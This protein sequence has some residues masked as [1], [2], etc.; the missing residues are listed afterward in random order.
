MWVW[1]FVGLLFSWLIV[2]STTQQDEPA[3]KLWMY[4]TPECRSCL[5]AA[6]QIDSII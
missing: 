5:Y 4:I 3:F 1:V 6:S 2:P